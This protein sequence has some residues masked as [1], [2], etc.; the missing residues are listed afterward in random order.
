M[1]IALL[2]SLTAAADQGSLP[3]PCR[4]SSVLP[5]ANA[6]RLLIACADTLEL[7]VV[8]SVDGHILRHI[9]LPSTGGA[10]INNVAVSPDGREAAVSW[11]DGTIAFSREGDADQRTWHAPFYAN[12]LVFSPDGKRLYVDG[13][14]L[15]AA[16]AR[17][18]GRSLRGEFDA[19]N[20]IAF[21]RAGRKA[22]V[23]EAD[24]TIRMFD[25]TSGKQLRTFSFDVEPLVV[26]ADPETGEVITG[27]A[28][29]S[30]ARFDGQLRLI[31]TYPGVPGMM[32][33]QILST[34]T[35]LVAALSP[36][37]GG[38]APAPWM[39]DYVRGNWREL[40]AA[41][42]AVAARRRGRGV[43]VYKINGAALVREKLH[44]APK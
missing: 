22:F 2:L 11:R 28:D 44:L 43:E 18:T 15:E 14:E 38:A 19:P 4:S 20:A 32:P 30:V 17:P 25:V 13:T 29:G 34:G 9:A 33:V 8:S 1:I 10:A 35:R 40:P 5:A 24:T 39:L 6:D 26:D 42:G 31:R 7:N 41:K 12:S 3:L 23:A 27:L 21:D 37:S 16:T 36:Q